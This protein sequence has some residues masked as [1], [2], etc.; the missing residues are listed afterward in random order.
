[1]NP[2][3][4]VTRARFRGPTESTKFSYATNQLIHDQRKLKAILQDSNDNIDTNLDQLVSADGNN[5]KDL[6]H[7]GYKARL[8]LSNL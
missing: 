4:V 8:I 2:S 6:M 3:I 5:I 1:M 7:I